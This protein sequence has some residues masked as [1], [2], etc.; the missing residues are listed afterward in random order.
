MYRTGNFFRLD[1]DE[2]LDV[3][4]IEQYELEGVEYTPDAEEAVKAVD[5]ERGP[6]RVPRPRADG[7]AGVRL[8]H[9]AAR[10]CRRRRRTSIPS[11]PPACSC[12]PSRESLAGAVPGGRRRREGRARGDAH[13]RGARA[14]R[15]GSGEGGDITA[16]LDEAAERAVLAHF[17]RPDIRIVSEEIGIRGD[18]PITVVVD[19]I[20]GSQNAERAIP[21]FALC[22]AVAEGGQ[23]MD[24]VVFGF[25]HDFGSDEEW[26]AVQGRRRVPERRAADRARRRTT[27]SSSRSRRRAPALVL[28]RLEKLAPLT[29]RVRVMGAQAITFCHLAAG[30]TD[31]VVVPQAVAP[32]RLRGLPAADPRARVRHPRDR[33]A[34]PCPRS[35]S[36]S[37]ARSRICAAGTEEL[38]DADRRGGTLLGMEPSRDAILAALAN[39]IDPELRKPVTELDMVRDVDDL[40]R[41]GHRHDRA[42]R[43]RL[44]AAQLVPGAGRA[45]GRRR[46]GRHGGAARVR[47]DE[48][49]RSARR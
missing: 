20:D 33:R 49:R 8:R 24:D 43:R 44:P 38:A 46:R 10:R 19:P 9:A 45:R 7:R 13:A 28:D 12:C 17:D 5:D 36:T 42:H 22:V 32:G 47:R 2:E 30:R 11:S 6:A 25:V 18:G 3:D 4:E 21:Y 15:S 14:A 48:P 37:Q 34:R 27:S 41:R 39:V 1:S 23:T 16:A 35:R 29:D 40:G 31:A 26:T